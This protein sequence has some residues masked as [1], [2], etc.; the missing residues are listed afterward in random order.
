MTIFLSVELRLFRFGLLAAGSLGN[1][2]GFQAGGADLYLLGDAVD[3]GADR[4]QVGIPASIGKIMG[5][6]YI[7]TESRRLAADFTYF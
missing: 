6:G 1:L 5:V 4:L 3:Q 2:A 7:M